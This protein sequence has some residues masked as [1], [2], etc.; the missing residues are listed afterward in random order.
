M[1]QRT[2]ECDYSESGEGKPLSEVIRTN[3]WP[4]G[5][6]PFFEWVATRAKRLEE[7]ENQKKPDGGAREREKEERGEEGE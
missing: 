4:A 1:H 5:R 6:Q 3:I 2:F 7:E